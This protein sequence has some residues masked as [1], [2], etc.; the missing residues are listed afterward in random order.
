MSVLITYLSDR[1]NRKNVLMVITTLCHLTCFIVP[2]SKSY[3]PVLIWRGLSGALVISSLPIYLSIL[4]D[5]Y[6]PSLRSTASV[7]SST[8]VGFGMLAGQTISGFLSSRFGWRFFFFIIPIIGLL[9]TL[10]LYCIC[11]F[12]LLMID[13][14]IPEKG[15]ADGLYQQS[16]KNQLSTSFHEILQSLHIPSNILRNFINHE[17]SYC[18]FLARFTRINSMG[19][20]Q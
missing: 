10:A 1:Y 11:Y 20:L 14:E 3:Y 15:E 18:S 2:L 9:S 8:V 16:H 17:F 4:G 13:V 7:I 6:P 19:C 5:V 12:M